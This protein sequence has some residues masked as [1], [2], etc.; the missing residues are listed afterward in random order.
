MTLSITVGTA[1]RAGAM[2]FV[3]VAIV[4][5]AFH[6]KRGDP[7]PAAPVSSATSGVHNDPLQAELKRCQLLG[8][9]GAEDD[10]CLRAWAENR[11]RFL[12]LPAPPTLPP[13]ETVS[14]P[15]PPPNASPNGAPADRPA[16]KGE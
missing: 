2:A 16:P 15:L 9:A 7:K 10:H 1:A 14:K 6:I 3:V 8:E 5:T 11:R 13:T 4:T 12:R